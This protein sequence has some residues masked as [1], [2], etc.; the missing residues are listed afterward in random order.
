MKKLIIILIVLISSTSFAAKKHLKKE[1]KLKHSYE[2]YVDL[3]GE[4]DTSRAIIELFFDKREFNAVAKMSFLPLTL[5]VAL[6]VPPIGIGLMGLSSPLFIGGVLTRRRYNHK[7]L[8]A[9][10]EKYNK[11]GELSTRIKKQVKLVLLAEHE[12]SKGDFTL[13]RKMAL[14]SMEMNTTKKNVILVVN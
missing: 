12:E 5:G 2:E 10:L 1:S 4:N 13:A 6:I 14:R 9:V 8:M 11:T 3:Y 7:N